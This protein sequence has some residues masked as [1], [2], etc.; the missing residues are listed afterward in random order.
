[1]LLRLLVPFGALGLVLVVPLMVAALLAVVGIEHVWAWLFGVGRRD[2]SGRPHSVLAASNNSG[3]CFSGLFTRRS[4]GVP[5][6]A[7]SASTSPS[8]AGQSAAPG[9][10]AS[11]CR[12]IVAVDCSLEWRSSVALG[13]PET[14]GAIASCYCI[15]A[16]SPKPVGK[17]VDNWMTFL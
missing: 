6:G 5:S 9:S 8:H 12:V 13:S 1:M 7:G 3:R 17:S 2:R 15:P 11:R 14:A 10:A 4:I 16:L